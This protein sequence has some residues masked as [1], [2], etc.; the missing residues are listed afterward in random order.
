MDVL[1]YMTP[2]VEQLAL[3]IV[4]SGVTMV[5]MVLCTKKSYQYGY[6]TNT[7]EDSIPSNVCNMNQTPSQSVS[8]LVDSKLLKKHNMGNNS[9]FDITMIITFNVITHAPPC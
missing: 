3:I 7:L 8:Q 2:G 5:Q 9:Y 4:P 6:V 1:S